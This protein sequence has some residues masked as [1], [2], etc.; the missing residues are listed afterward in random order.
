LRR[1]TGRSIHSSPAPAPSGWVKID[2]LPSKSSVI[3]LGSFSQ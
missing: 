1:T 3:L 2:F